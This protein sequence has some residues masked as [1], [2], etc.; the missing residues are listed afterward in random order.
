VSVIFFFFTIH[1]H[2]TAHTH[3]FI[4]AD[5][6]KVDF[7]QGEPLDCLKM[8]AHSHNTELQRSAALAFAE[9]TEKGKL[10]VGIP[11][12]ANVFTYIKKILG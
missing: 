5:R 10:I 9:V 12:R 1:H 7:Y 2:F 8:L 6:S 11:S 4:K 3:L